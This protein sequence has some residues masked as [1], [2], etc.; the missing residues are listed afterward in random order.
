MSGTILYGHFDYNSELETTMLQKNQ[1]KAA[2][3]TIAKILTVALSILNLFT[4]LNLAIKNVE[5]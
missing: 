4:E 1:L 3:Y 5:T 2:E